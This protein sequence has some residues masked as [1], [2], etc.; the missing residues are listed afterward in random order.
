MAFHLFLGILMACQRVSHRKAS[1]LQ[2]VGRSNHAEATPAGP[3][4]E[5]RHSGRSKRANQGVFS[6]RFRYV[7]VTFAQRHF[8]EIFVQFLAGTATFLCGTVC[9]RSGFCSVSVVSR[10]FGLKQRVLATFS[11]QALLFPMFLG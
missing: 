8:R 3:Q 7:F 9:F 6:L 11:A 10:V 1:P 2:L 4:F 5:T